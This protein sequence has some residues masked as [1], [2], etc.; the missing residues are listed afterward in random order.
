MAWVQSTCPRTISTR[1]GTAAAVLAVPH[2]VTL[3][4]VADPAGGWP[5]PLHPVIATVTR[6]A[7]PRNLPTQ[8][9]ARFRTRPAWGG[10]TGWKGGCR[11]ASRW[12]VPA[13]T[14]G[15]NCLG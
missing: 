2:A 4:L 6:T 3:V 10:G 11:W 8:A 9:R 1:T 12:S 7:I 5:E 14:P 15:A 13:G